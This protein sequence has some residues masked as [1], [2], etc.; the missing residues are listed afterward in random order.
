MTKNW[1]TYIA[2]TCSVGIISCSQKLTVVYYNDSSKVDD[3]EIYGEALYSFFDP[4]KNI[5]IYEIY[6]NDLDKKLQAVIDSISSRSLP[7][8]PDDAYY[9]YAFITA[10]RDTLF[11]DYRLSY[12]K[13]HNKSVL[14]KNEKLKILI[15]DKV[16]K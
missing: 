8:E 7:Q 11:A 16:P 1:K 12:W 10:S 14:Y 3:G 4:D 2:V 13:Y 15:R 6:S 9:N 5:H